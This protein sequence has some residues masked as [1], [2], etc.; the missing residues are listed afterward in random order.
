MVAAPRSPRRLAAGLLLLL[1]AGPAA[2]QA[3]DVERRAAAMRQVVLEQL[4]AFRRGDWAAAYGFASE[5]IHSQFT[6]ES[7]R[8]MV[9][10]GYPAIAASASATVLRTEAD[11][12]QKGYVEIRV[13]GQDGEAIDALYELI[14]QQGAW[15]VNGVIAKPAEKGDLVR[16]GA[17]A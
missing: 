2:A 5:S 8:Q 1:L 9:T 4:A 12:P 6:P 17:R 14:D 15:K 16:A 13:Q 7:F 3:P 11:D 10:R